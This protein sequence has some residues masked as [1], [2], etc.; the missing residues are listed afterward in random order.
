MK[1]SK[2]NNNK[3]ALSNWGSLSQAKQSSKNLAFLRKNT[4][5]ALI[6]TTKKSY[7]MELRIWSTAD[8][9]ITHLGPWG[10]DYN[11]IKSW[12]LSHSWVHLK[13]KMGIPIR[14]EFR[15]QHIGMEQEIRLTDKGRDII[16][17]SL[18]KYSSYLKKT[19]GKIS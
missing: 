16:I 11:V 19:Y 18:K 17:K 3:T 14:V 5:E 2:H 7:L 15:G 9:E 13:T 8:G 10:G 1:M 12:A 6:T 4:G